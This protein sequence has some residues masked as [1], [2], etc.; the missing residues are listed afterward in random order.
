[1]HHEVPARSACERV[2]TASWPEHLAPSSLASLH[3]PAHRLCAP[4]AAAVRFHSRHCHS[5]LFCCLSCCSLL[6][7]QHCLARTLPVAS[8]REGARMFCPAVPSFHPACLL[9]FAERVGGAKSS[10]P[11]EQRASGVALFSTS[12]CAHTDP[13]CT[14]TAAVA[15]HADRALVQCSGSLP[16]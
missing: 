11:G 16:S 5:L 8:M 9:F 12:S 6:Q 4:A 7:H 13:P 1:M 3:T 10:L 14:A 15:P 2:R